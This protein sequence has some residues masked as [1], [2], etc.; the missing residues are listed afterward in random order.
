MMLVLFSLACLLGCTIASANLLE[1]A[2]QGDVKSIINAWNTA[3]ESGTQL[4]LNTREEDSLRTPLMEASIWGKSEVVAWLLEN[5]ADASIPEKD[6]YTPMH[7]AAFQGH[8]NVAKVLLTKGIS[9][10]QKH[11]DGF[12]PVFRSTWGKKPRHEEAMKFFIEEAGVSVNTVESS[13]KMTLLISA[14]KS[15]NPN[16]MKYLLQVGASVNAVDKEGNTA[17]HYVTKSY[18]HAKALEA[19]TI[20]MKW[21]PDLTIVNKKGKT[22]LDIAKE[23]RFKSDEIIRILEAAQLKDEL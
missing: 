7:G 10:D 16:I 18:D 11:E 4:D 6:G 19:T 21:N 23:N 3:K 14:A 17:M 8:S 20:M 22:A 5:G 13:S 15:L 12:T 1:W 2:R 9:V